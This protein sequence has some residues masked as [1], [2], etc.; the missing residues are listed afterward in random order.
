MRGRAGWR[1]RVQIPMQRGCINMR[2]E[3][4]CFFTEYVGEDGIGES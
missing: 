1:P 2:L 3:K 4:F